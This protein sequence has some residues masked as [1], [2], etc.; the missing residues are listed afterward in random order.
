M[1]KI[2]ESRIAELIALL[3]IPNE[4]S[5]SQFPFFELNYTGNILSDVAIARSAWKSV[6]RGVHD[7]IAHVVFAHCQSPEEVEALLEEICG[8]Y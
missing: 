1:S 3:K 8:T 5:Y 4:I 7:R 6:D 2:S